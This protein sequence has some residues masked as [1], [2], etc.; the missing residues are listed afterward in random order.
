MSGIALALT[1][2]AVGSSA[3]WGL[4]ALALHRCVLELRKGERDGLTGLY[5]REAFEKRAPAAL[6]AANAVALLDL[7]GFKQINDTLGHDAGDVVLRAI[8]A[9]LTAGLGPSALIARLGGDEFAVI[10]RLEFP[11]VGARLDALAAAL[12]KPVRVAEERSVGVGVS[13]GVAALRDLPTFAARPAE[14]KRDKRFWAHVLT[15]GLS[16]ADTVMYIAKDENLDWRLFDPRRDPVVPA[17]RV[18]RAPVRRCREHGP[19]AL[20]GA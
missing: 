16:A 19:A 1:A 9:R 10:A 6:A 18:D 3:G 15:E 12:T 5:R 17:D 2:A 4:T 20:I 14:P 11:D 8:A 13:L 7:D